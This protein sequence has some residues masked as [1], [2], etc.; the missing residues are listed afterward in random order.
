M[1][2]EWIVPIELLRRSKLGSRIVGLLDEMK[3]GRRPCEMDGG[4]VEP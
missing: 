1:V 3:E 2:M 4:R